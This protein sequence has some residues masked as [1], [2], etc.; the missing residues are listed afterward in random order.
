MKMWIWLA[1]HVLPIIGGMF[2][3]F[4]LPLGV[5]IFSRSTDMLFFPVGVILLGLSYYY[6][7][8]HKEKQ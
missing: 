6:G 7:F 5:A 1:K 4:S 3:G 2:I 8:I